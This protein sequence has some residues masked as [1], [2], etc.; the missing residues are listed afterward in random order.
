MELVFKRPMPMTQ[1]DLAEVETIEYE[2]YSFP[3]TRG[4]FA[5]SIDSGYSAWV[6]RD[7]EKMLGYCVVMMSFDEAHLL[8]ISVARQAQGLGVGRYLLD[9]IEGVC[10]RL[11]AASM[12]LEVRPSNTLALGFYERHGYGR[13]GVRRSYYPAEFGR[14]DAIVMRKTLVGANVSQVTR[15][16][17][18]GQ[19]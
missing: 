6:V 14:E 3:W 15:S 7:N 2:V 11:G 8:N 17:A 13:I 12:L 1:G 5:D 10:S 16:A 4:N 19:A 9:W 18:G